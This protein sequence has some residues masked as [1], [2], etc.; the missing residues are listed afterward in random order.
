MTS[1]APMLPGISVQRLS[2]E[3]GSDHIRL[4]FP[5]TGNRGMGE[6]IEPLSVLGQYQALKST[7][8]RRG[9]K[10][11]A[12]VS[13]QRLVE[14]LQALLPDEPKPLF[15]RTGWL[16]HGGRMGFAFPDKVVGKLGAELLVDDNV[17]TY[18]VSS[19]GTSGKLSHWQQSVARTAL[20]SR[21]ASLAIMTAFASPLLRYSGLSESFTLNIAGESSSGKSTAV[22]AAISVW[23]HP[24]NCLS[25]DSTDGAI[26][27]LAVANSGL[28]LFLD[29]IEKSVGDLDAKV[30]RVRNMIHKIVSGTTRTHMAYAERD[31]LLKT[32]RYE[33]IAFCS[34]PDTIEKFSRDARKPLLPS[35]RVRF[36]EIK[37]PV[38]DAGGIFA[39]PACGE[40]SADSRALAKLLKDSAETHF[41]KAGRKW[42]RYLVGQEEKLKS[43][44][45]SL[46]DEFLRRLGSHVKAIEGRIADKFALVFAAGVLASRAGIL[47]WNEE[48]ISDITLQSYR[49]AISAGFP[50][51]F[52][53]DEA[54][55]RLRALVLDTER[56]RRTSKQLNALGKGQRDGYI[57]RGRLNLR[58]EAF[59]EA[60]AG[61]A[62]GRAPPKVD[63]DHLYLR[64][65]ASG[66]LMKG[67]GGRTQDVWI[68]GSKQKRLVFDMRALSREFRASRVALSLPAIGN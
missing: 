50:D 40:R 38:G 27:D 67:Y 59:E 62:T 47:P 63:L 32:R 9:Y 18:S 23:G 20:K 3:F 42:I 24:K 17:R 35:D 13:G 43:V 49:D 26:T 60:L 30:Q 52:D 6:V 19:G 22:A 44:V 15:T 16:E 54:M 56:V 5:R 10:L 7:L 37:V 65:Q 4:T 39:V 12:G 57:T 31:P 11:P 33:C 53:T 48:T 45:A 58:R 1:D 34:S 41:G 14:E 64:L 68:A 61:P 25:W 66:A 36:L 28:G 46:S 51:R 29:D 55:L 8:L 21:V 2:D